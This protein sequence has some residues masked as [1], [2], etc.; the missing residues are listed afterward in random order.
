MENLKE[1]MDKEGYVVIPNIFS[2][3][4]IDDIALRVESSAKKNIEAGLANDD[5]KTIEYAKNSKKEV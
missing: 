3:E 5:S 1:Q 4:E 2:S